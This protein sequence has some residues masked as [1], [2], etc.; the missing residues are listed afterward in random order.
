MRAKLPVVSDSATPWTA[1]CQASLSITNSQSLLKLMSIESVMPA[2][3]LLSSLSPAFNLF[4]ASGSFPMNL[5]FPGISRTLLQTNWILSPW[6]VVFCH[7]FNLAWQLCLSMLLNLL[8]I[9]IYLATLGLSCCMWAPPIAACRISSCDVQPLSCST[10][11][12]VPWPGIES[13]LPALGAWSL[14]CWTAT[15]VPMLLYFVPFYWWVAMPYFLHPN[16]YIVGFFFKWG[17]GETDV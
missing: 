12:L 17:N 1:A 7:F 2:C 4:P 3:P 15:E 13:G 8:K 16:N 9:F 6:L 5:W 10:W 11:D 14:S